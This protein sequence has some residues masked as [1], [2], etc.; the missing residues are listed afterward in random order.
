MEEA[1]EKL[2]EVDRLRSTAIEQYGPPR[3][4]VIHTVRCHSPRAEE[5]RY[6]EPPWVVETGPYNAH[7][8]GSQSI[9]NFELYLERNKEVS[10]IVYK[11]YECCNG[12]SGA[13]RQGK[14]QKDFEVDATAFLRGERIALIAPELKTALSEVASHS[15]E[16]MPHP[17]FVSTDDEDEDEILYPY[18][19]YFHRRNEIH[20]A[21]DELPSPSC[22]YADCF[23]GYIQDRM[24]EEWET[25][26]GLLGE[27]RITAEYIDY[28]FVSNLDLV[29]CLMKAR[30]QNPIL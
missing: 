17:V 21:I 8:R 25:V 27:N 24:T 16:G 23:R 10:F 11:E 15:L 1:S 12:A 18:I 5:K 3:A 19:W 26:L 4:Q 22:R 2:R 14:Y 30:L 28:L 6:L 13:Y 20:R 7:L 9:N 29:S